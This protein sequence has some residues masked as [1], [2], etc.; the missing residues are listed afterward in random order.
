MVQFKTKIK[1]KGLDNETNISAKQ[2]K[3]SQNTWIF[4]KDVDQTGTKYYK[5]KKS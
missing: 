1:L 4:K 5:E 2:I 3:K